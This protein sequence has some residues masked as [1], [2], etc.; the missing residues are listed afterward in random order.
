MIIKKL[1][2]ANLIDCPH[3]LPDNILYLTITGSMA[4]GVNTDDSDLDIVGFCAPE[5]SVVFPHTAG[6]IK[7][8]GNQGE[9]FDQWQMHHV[10]S[11]DGKKEYDFTVYSIVKYFDLCMANN[12]NMIDTLFTPEN[13]VIHRTKVS[14]IVRENRKLF[15]HKGSWHKFKGYAFAQMKKIKGGA[16]QSNPK[17][18]EATAQFGYDV[19]FGYHVC[20]LML[21]I[22]QILTEGDLDL[23][24]NREQLKSIRRGEWSLERLEQYFADK[25][26]SL[27]QVYLDSKLP[28]QADEKV[29]R[30]VLLRCLE[31]HFGSL[32]AMVVRDTSKDELL[33]EMRR[34][35]E[36]HGG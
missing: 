6:I 15:L 32:E 12:P 20:R 3:W 13:C 1:K 36:K 17:R 25:E 19:K 24:R 30:E 4:Y 18:A 28:Y 33:A 8:F 11:E 7:N 23:Q 5:R 21:E 27:E 9:Q 31:E 29:I 16:N 22:E 26:K 2:A 10:K 14:D 35:L 34:V